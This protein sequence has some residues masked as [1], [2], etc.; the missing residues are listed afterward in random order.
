MAMMFP[1]MDPY[2]ESP[3]IWSGVH[4]RFIVYLADQLKPRLSPRYI[5][6]VEERVFV[7]G[8]NREVIPD[9]CLRQTRNERTGNPIAVA[10][11]DAPVLVQASSLE[12]HESYLT[13]L[14]R[15]SGQ[16]IVTVIGLT[17]PTN[18]YS[19]PGRV[20]YVDKQKEVLASDT[21]LVEID[22]LR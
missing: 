13:I 4:S 5:A 6:A 7:E 2:L 3:Q 11:E 20:L 19:G 18:K 21:H 14:D 22:L 10:E 8:P 17:S 16:R 12:L 9:V 1:G 15:Q